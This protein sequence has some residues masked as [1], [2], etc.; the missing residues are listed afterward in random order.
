MTW[1]NVFIEWLYA[2][3]LAAGGALMARLLL[4]Y[5]DR[6]AGGHFKRWIDN[7]NSTDLAIYYGARFVGVGLLFGLALS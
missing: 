1:V 4:A 2:I 3:S 7:A 5:F 6:R